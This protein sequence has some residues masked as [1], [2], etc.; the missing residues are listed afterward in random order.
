MLAARIDKLPAAQK[1]LLQTLAVVGRESPLGLLRKVVSDSSAQLEQAL[2]ELRSA[3]FIYEQ[4]AP[5]E[6]EYVFKHALTQEVA[7]NSLLIERRKQLHERVAQAIET[8]YANQLEDRVATLAHQYSHSD[9]ADKAIEYLHRT[10]Q[11]AIKRSAHPDAIASL[12]S[13]ISLLQKLPENPQRI[14]TELL[15]QI[16]LGQALLPVKGFAAPEVEDAFFRAHQLAQQLGNPPD[17]FF[18]LL[19]LRIVH[20]IRAK[21]ESARELDEKLLD[22][23]QTLKD[24]GLLSLVNWLQ[25]IASYQIGEMP[26][27]REQLERSLS[28]YDRERDRPRS[29]LLGVDPGTGSLG[30]LGM[31]LWALGYPD[32]AVKAGE[33]GVELAHDLPHSG[34]GCTFFLASVHQFR[35]EAHE[36]QRISERVID[37]SAEHGFTLWLHLATFMRRWALIQQGAGD[38]SVAQLREALAAYRATEAQIGRPYHLWLLA[39]AST[40]LGR[41]S[42]ALEALNEASL[43]AQQNGEHN[44]DAEIHRLNGEILLKQGDSKTAEAERC[45]QRGVESARRQNAKSLELRATMSLGRLLVSQGRREEARTMLADIYNW[46]TEGFDTAD[47]KDAK[48]LLDE[49]NVAAG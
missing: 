46:F 25:G 47:L 2:G 21:Y 6:N 40:K 32:Q 11:Q 4:P 29:L 43:V 20:F 41:W 22:H 12:S 42:D 18:V 38:S 23:A 37:V 15:V 24:P 34:C 26:L 35:R 7:Y 17:L 30:Y 9:N 3:E 1:E 10:G 39:D 19:G 5:G 14:Q 31:T 48:A 44:W 13:A 27:A 36:A 49:L 8:L 33:A 45:F 28:L 16:T